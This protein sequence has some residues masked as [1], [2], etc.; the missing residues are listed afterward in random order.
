VS[1]R[2]SWLVWAFVMVLAGGM[3]TLAAFNGT[4]AD[5]PI[6]TPMFLSFVMG[7][8]TVGALIA[9]KNRTNRIGWLMVVA[10]ISLALA[11]LGD[12][13]LRFATETRP[14]SLPG[15]PIAALLSN[16]AWGPL[17][18]VLTLVTLLFPTGSVPGPRWRLLPPAI[19]ALLGLGVVGLLLKPGSIDASVTL[20]L[21]NPL[22]VESLGRLADLAQAV[23][24][25]GLF[26]AFAASIAALA[27]RFR[28]SQPE[29]RQQIRWLAYVASVVGLLILVAIAEDALWSLGSFGDALFIS[30][31]ALIGLG[32]PAAI[33]V[34]ILRYRLYDLDLVVK[35]T[36]LYATVAFLLTALFVAIAFVVG[37]LGGRTQTGAVVAAAAIGLGFWPALRLAK[38]VA[39]RVVYG[40]RATPYE[41]LADF[42]S[43][44]GASYGT[45]D[46]LPRMASILA[47]AVGASR[48]I[49]WLRVGEELR[50]AAE[51]PVGDH[52]PDPIPLSGSGLPELPGDAAV[53]VRDL[54]ELL[55]ALAVSMPANDPMNV[56][57]ERLVRDLASQAGLVLRNVRLIEEL[58]ASRQRLVAAQ[59]EERRRLERNIHDGAQQQL[60]AL[61]VKLRL[62]ERLT[63]RDAASAAQMASELQAEA[64]QAL[65]DLRDLARG[66][67]P[68]L[69]AD[70]G[71]AAALEAQVRR[72]P[73]PVEVVTDGVGRYP[74]ELESALYFC[75]LE[76]LQ[77]VAKY[78]RAAR[79]EIRLS[80]TADELAFEVID[81]GAGFDPE[82]AT[83]GS[84]LQGMSD[85]LSA[86]GG[87]L[88][89][90]SRPGGGTSV[91][92]RVPLRER[93]NP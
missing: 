35:K 61:G 37:A 80:A 6:L 71:L 55:G 75:C 14:G 74:P 15:A 38:R 44:V 93:R 9:S 48:A 59:D 63:T 5:D 62:L 54:G 56:R 79:A 23:G 87:T 85:R 88:Q 78:A 70:E 82:S 64:M 90:R 67:Y 8:S 1:L 60:V 52:L 50:P 16:L 29:E 40:R 2:A 49:V 10:G 32:V 57:K 45:E 17:F 26:P 4:I 27:I 41:V 18:A 7:Y 84:G 22:G 13:Y 76:A 3:L 51:A 92:G 68:P 83:R 25:I 91:A 20:R 28:R 58:R 12:E 31:V 65:D 69:L 11:G 33:G 53:E 47:G 72:S 24:F 73:I 43:R 30:T 66:I 36:V 77:N 46:V 34:A 21:E 86:I 42:S 19:L 39:D 81:D 89:V